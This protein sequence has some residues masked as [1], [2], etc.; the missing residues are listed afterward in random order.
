[1]IN[2]KAFTLIELLVVVLIIGILAAV[3]LPQYKLAVAKSRYATIKDLTNSIAQ[4]EEVYYLTNGHYSSNFEELDIDMPSGKL[5]TSTGNN[6]VYDWGKCWLVMTTNWNMI[7]CQR[8][9]ISVAYR[10]FLHFSERADGASC[11]I[12]GTTDLSDWHNKICKQETH[13][14]SISSVTDNQIGWMYP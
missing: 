4:A 2:K 13:G 7:T 6:Y 1:M 8:D 12:F 11:M 14:T 3:A 10:K 5:S 9:D